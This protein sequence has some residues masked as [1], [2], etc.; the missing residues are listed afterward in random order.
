LLVVAAAPFV[1]QGKPPSGGFGPAIEG[2]IGYQGQSKCAPSPKPGVLAFQ[3]MVLRAYPGTGVG[4]IGRACNIGGQSEHKEGRA[5]DWTV[6]VSV[7][8]QRAAA[9]SLIDWLLK[10]DRYG[11]EAA[12]ARRLGIMYLIWNRK[13]WG[14]WGGWQVYCVQKPN[15]CKEPGK[16]GSLRHP[17]T[18]HV[19]FSFTWPGARKETSYWHKDRS[20]IAALGSSL[21]GGRWALGRNGA[22]M[23]IASWSYGSLADLRIIKEPAVGLAATPYGYGYWIATKDGKV[24]AFGDAPSKGSA[25]GDTTK[26]AGIVATPS[27][28]GYWL[29]TRRGRVFA[30]GDADHLGG[31]GADNVVATGMAATPTGLGYWLVTQRGYVTAFGDALDLGDAEDVSDISGMAVT[32]TGLGYWLFTKKGRVIALG[33]ARFFG[34]LAAKKIGQDVVGLTPST[35]GLGYWLLGSKGKLKAFGDAPRQESLTA[36]APRPAPPKGLSPRILPGD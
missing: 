12:M 11:N 1:A 6:N 8:Y 2:Y 19:H 20:M 24:K 34:G 27:G 21:S 28:R 3:A 35:T 4:G 29:Y 5:W 17:H 16:G 13:I 18:D 30:F 25:K 15:G 10:P 23:P 22:V 32:P 14:S 7:P 36:P 9:E 31:L 33:D 26:L